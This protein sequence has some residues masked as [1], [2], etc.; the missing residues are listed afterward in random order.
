MEALRGGRQRLTEQVLDLKAGVAE[1]DSCIAQ[2]Q[3]QLAC[4]QLAAQTAE[5]T[6]W[7]FETE[8]ACCC[9]TVTTVGI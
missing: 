7:A 3:H 4:A 6:I 8:F 9:C 1:R 5:V 2:L